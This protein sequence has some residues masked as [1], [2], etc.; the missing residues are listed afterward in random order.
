MKI[1]KKKLP[2]FKLLDEKVR[3][4]YRTDLMAKIK[5]LGYKHVSEY[6]YDQYYRLYNPISEIA[7][8]LPITN[9]DIFSWMRRWEFQTRGKGGNT[10][11]RGLLNRKV[12]RRIQK[13]KGKLSVTETA[14]SY[15]C[16][17]TAVRS[18]WKKIEPK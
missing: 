16:S 3:F 11:N 4:N 9:S 17:D 13:A 18:I 15:K 1:K 6:V 10:K 12:V 14:N 2:L 7:K 5:E 8:K